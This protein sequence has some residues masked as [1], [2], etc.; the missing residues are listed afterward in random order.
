MAFI[1]TIP[2]DEWGDELAAL[3]PAVRDP[4]TGRVDN[5][6]AI[7]SLNPASLAAHYAVYA[8]AMTGT[9]SLRKVDRELI[10]LVVSQIND[11]H[12]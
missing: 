6:L 3:A 4:A 5:I 9:R 11:C 7:H 2:D 10:A 1:E 8:S 12:Y